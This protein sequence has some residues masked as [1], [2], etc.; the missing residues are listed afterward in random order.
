MLSCF[1]RMMVQIMIMLIP[2]P[3]LF[4]LPDIVIALR[5]SAAVKLVDQC[6]SMCSRRANCHSKTMTRPKSTWRFDV[7]PHISDKEA[8]MEGLVN[9]SM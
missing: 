5:P 4:A 8:R 9:N 2:I 1:P 3:I 7:I 6:K